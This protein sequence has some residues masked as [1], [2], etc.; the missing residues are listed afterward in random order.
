M[1]LLLAGCA[2]EGA[3]PAPAGREAAG[4]REAA[5]D[6]MPAGLRAAFVR[7][8]Q[9]DAPARYAWSGARDAR[10]SEVR[11][12]VGASGLR[13]ASDAWGGAA[14][15]AAPGPRG[16]ARRARGAAG[17][18]GGQRGAPGAARDGGAVGAWPARGRAP[19][20]GGGASGRHGSAG[21][22]A[23]G[24]GAGGAAGGRGGAAGGRGRS[25]R[26]LRRAVGGGRGRRGG[27]LAPR[28]ARRAGAP[29]RRGRARA[30]PAAHRSLVATEQAKLEASDGATN[31]FFGTSVALDGDTALVGA[32]YDDTSRGANAGS[33]YVF[34][35]SGPTWTEQ[36]RLEASDGAAGDIFGASVALDGDTALV[37][38]IGDDTSRGTN[39]GSAYVF[40]RSGPTWTEQARLEASD[41][42][43]NDVFG[44]SVALDGDSALVG[45]RWDDTARGADAGSAYV[46]VRSSTTWT[47]Q[48]KLE[49]SDGA[50]Y[51]YFGTS[52]ALDGD[53]AL[54]GADGDDTG[55][56]GDAGSAYVFVRSG[57]TW[58]EQARLEASDGAVYDY[59]G[60]SVALDGDSALVGADRDDTG[61]GTDA[62]SAYVFSAQRRHVDPAGEARGERRRGVGLLRRVGRAGRGHRAGGRVRG[63]YL[64]RRARRLGLRLRAQRH[65]VDRAGEARGERRRGERT[66]RSPGRAGRGHRAGGRARR[67]HRARRGRRLGLRLRAPARGRRSVRG[68][69]PMRER[70]LHGRSLLRQRVRRRRERLPGVQRRR[71]RHGERHLHGAHGGCRPGRRLPAVRGRVRRRRELHGRLD[72]VPSRRVRER[73]HR[74]PRRGGRLRRRRA[75]HRLVRG[76]PGRRA[77]GRGHRVPRVRRLVRCRRGVHRYR[78]RV[79]GRRAG[80]RGHRVPAVRRP[81]RPPPRRAPA[82]AARAPPTSSPPRAPSAARLP[83]PATSPRRAPAPAARARRTCSWPRA[84]SAARPPAPATSPRRAPAPAARARPTCSWPQAPSAARPPAPATSPRRAPAPAARA[85]PTPSPPRVPS[86]AAAGDCDLAEACT[87]SAAS[88]PADALAA[89]GTG[90]PRRGGRLRPR[91]VMHR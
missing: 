75:L 88:C 1:T 30:L 55:R 57:T 53:T 83:A 38:A 54:V 13:A 60:V 90:V 20:R 64:A 4:E 9:E 58:T 14:L 5:G 72:R 71:G 59:F 40:V 3:A 37:G 69:R 73:E 11:W 35:R 91:G 80:G 36:A 16:R 48:A 66:L 44:A 12:Q 56:G 62:G 15:D 18:G 81:L 23:G 84:P 8:V 52:V 43:T 47:E 25:A 85:R 10:S 89:A 2:P 27:A 7:A 70:L 45:M 65:D 6:E 19:A 34:V 67:R 86:R 51:D 24:R 41:G 50:A 22:G 31:D 28:S 82:P 29:A 78:Q 74:V 87:G 76:V 33:A 46:F 63:R 79:P 42:A 61:R 21:S 77:G 32:S 49:A 68:R 26:A 17:R 39:A